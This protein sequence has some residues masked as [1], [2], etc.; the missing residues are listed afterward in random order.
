MAQRDDR[1]E[2]ALSLWDRPGFLVRRLHQISV[3]IF[4]DEMGDLDITPVQFG[5]LSIVAANPGIDQSALARELGIDRANVADVVARLSANG[6]IERRASARDR[7]AKSILITP[8]G[9]AHLKEA[10]NRFGKVHRRLL[11][12]L[13]GEERAVFLDLLMR[14]IEGNNSLGRAVLRLEPRAEPAA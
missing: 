7:R 1:T 12:P 6:H 10:N 4:M 14:L 5:A 9:K 3:A 11:D 13:S 2:E 8:E